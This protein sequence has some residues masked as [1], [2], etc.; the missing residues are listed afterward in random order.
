V[1]PPWGDGSY[2]KNCSSMGSS[3]WATV[4]ARTLLQ[5]G[6]STGPQFPS[7]YIHLLWHGVLHK[8]QGE[9]LLHLG[10]L[11]TV[12][13]QPASPWSHCRLQEDLCSGSWCTSFY[14][15][16]DLGVCRVVSLTYFPSSF[17]AAAVRHFLLQKYVITEVLPTSL[18]GSAFTS[19]GSLDLAE[20]GSAQH[21]GNF[22][23]LLTEA[24]PTAPLLP[25]PCLVNQIHYVTCYGILLRLIK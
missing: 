14:F 24:I 19:S 5:C 11:W 22:C 25:K 12:E 21:G 3:P 7:G 17:P 2:Q 1:G 10:S 16:T 18:M 8:M 9:Y 23:H 4:P 20:T 6:I 15:F 13:G